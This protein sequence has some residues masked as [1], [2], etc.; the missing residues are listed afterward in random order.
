MTTAQSNAAQLVSLRESEAI[1]ADCG[2]SGRIHLQNRTT[3]ARK[4]G[5]TTYVR[6]LQ[7]GVLSMS[8]R[9]KMGGRPR[10]LTL[11]D[12]TQRPGGT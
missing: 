6:S 1:C 9:G 11:V 8:E 7:P 10:R 4:G 5:N 2:G 3:R 12:I